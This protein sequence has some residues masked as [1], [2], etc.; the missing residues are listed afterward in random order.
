G[1]EPAPEASAEGS[2]SSAGGSRI[3][4]RF[5]PEPRSTPV[6]LCVARQ[7]GVHPL[8]ES[9]ELLHVAAKELFG[10]WYRDLPVVGHQPGSE[11]DVSLDG[12][13]QRGV[14]EGE[15]RPQVLLADRRTDLTR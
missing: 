1:G 13:H 5:S 10:G 3:P 11:M 9:F 4:G 2:P 8:D 12:V 14:A 15:D 7:C 6:P